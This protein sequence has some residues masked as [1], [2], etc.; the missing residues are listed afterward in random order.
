MK[1]QQW[2]L[3]TQ[4]DFFE[5]LGQLIANGYALERALMTV[6]GVLP[7]QRLALI[8][9]VAGLH[10]GQ[11]LH[12]LLAPYVRREIAR[13]LAFASVHAGDGNWSTGTSSFETKS[14]APPI[15]TLSSCATGDVSGLNGAILYVSIASITADGCNSATA[16]ALGRWFK[17]ECFNL[18]CC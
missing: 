18:L 16:V 13:E 7:K 8:A 9:I 12:Q 11:P 10:Q 17:R 5:L 4:A 1:K 14:E 3:K 15:T 6:Q 2:P